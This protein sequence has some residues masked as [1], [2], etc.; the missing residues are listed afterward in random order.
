MFNF[1]ICWKSPCS[2]RT[3][4]KT[5]IPCL[6]IILTA[7]FTR[8]SEWSG[9]SS[10]CCLSYFQCSY[11]C[12]QSGKICYHCC[13]SRIQIIDIIY[14]SLHESLCYGF[15]IRR[16]ISIECCPCSVSD[17]EKKNSKYERNHLKCSPLQESNRKRRFLRRRRRSSII[18]TITQ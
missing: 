5:R 1:M 15:S 8:P 16:I 4:S 13:H 7:I 2:C 17:S 11:S 14:D 12:S 9:D 3:K 6:I 10:T 18:G